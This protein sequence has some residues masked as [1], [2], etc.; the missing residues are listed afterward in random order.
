MTSTPPD[1][2]AFFRTMLGE[3]E[4]IAN[5]VGGQ[6]LKSADFARTMQGASGAALNA[7]EAMK[8]VME[9][10][11][12]AANM[13]SRTELEDLSAR[14]ARIEAAMFRLEGKIDALG[15][16]PVPATSDATGLADASAAARPSR[17]RKPPAADP[18]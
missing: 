11:L 18:A 12:A 16:A 6:V 14:L 17:N 2:A 5:G 1:P 7:Q 4:K 3:W 8:G 10:A 13:P 15:A 9:R